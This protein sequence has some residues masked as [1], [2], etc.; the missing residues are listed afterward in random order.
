MSNASDFLQLL[1]TVL[2]VPAIA[3]GISWLARRFSKEA[4]LIIKLER[5]AAIYPNLPDGP[6]R[7]EFGRRV[8]EA[9]SELNARLDPLFKRERRR[10][11]KVIAWV[12]AASVVLAFLVPGVRGE[13][14]GNVVGVALG[15]AAVGGFL[16][17]ERDT[18]RQRAAIAAAEQADTLSG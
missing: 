7:E 2:S 6:I 10:K 8:S 15:L 4:R 13:G 5:L 14:V 1:V 12:L 16:L 18:K 11:W 9:G 17:I 3:A